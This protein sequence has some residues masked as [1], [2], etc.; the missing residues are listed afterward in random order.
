M[1]NRIVWSTITFI[2]AITVTKHIIGEF[3]RRSAPRTRCRIFRNT[4]VMQ[5]SF[6]LKRKVALFSHF[7]TG[8]DI[9]IVTYQEIISM[10]LFIFQSNHTFFF[11][12]LEK[13]I[14]YSL[15]LRYNVDDIE[16]SRMSEL[17]VQREYFSCS[18][19]RSTNIPH[20][21][22][23]VQFSF[24]TLKLRIFLSCGFNLSE[25]HHFECIGA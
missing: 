10:N 24:A 21:L 18:E 5:I 23:D 1:I 3:R 15:H 13:F 17:K 16:E 8:N 14:L 11:L 7:W 19:A 2:W 20:L 25:L 22:S 4:C 9:F 12:F 6:V